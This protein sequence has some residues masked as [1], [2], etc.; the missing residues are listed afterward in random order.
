M[1]QFPIFNPI[2]PVP[3][4]NR[5]CH[6]KYGKVV[7]YIVSLFT[8]VRIL[9]NNLLK[10]SGCRPLNLNIYITRSCIRAII[11]GLNWE[12]YSF[13]SSHLYFCRLT[14]SR[15]VPNWATVCRY[16]ISLMSWQIYETITKGENEMSG[17]RSTFLFHSSV[18]PSPLVS[19]TPTSHLMDG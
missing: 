13:A 17:I 9:M 4:N 7:F 5:Q 16:Y 11:N 19:F 3:A 10:E 14:I 15:F 8:C 1:G 6:W 18:F 12:F 2:I